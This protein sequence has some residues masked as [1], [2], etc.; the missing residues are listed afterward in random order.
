MGARHF[1]GEPLHI[2]QFHSSPLSPQEIFVDGLLV[3]SG[4]N[5]LAI[6]RRPPLL[7]GPAWL[8][9]GGASDIPDDIAES[10]LSLV[11]EAG[12]SH[13]IWPRAGLFLF[14]DPYLLI[15]R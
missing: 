8:N 7:T 2:I 9:A 12:K 13:P 10:D 15:A 14:H 3:A 4:E 11:E 1:A 5:K 6:Q